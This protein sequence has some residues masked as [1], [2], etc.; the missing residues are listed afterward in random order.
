MN[1]AE[2]LNKN[3]FSRES[4]SAPAVSTHYST[5]SSLIAT[6]MCT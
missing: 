4:G 2:I 6:C 5:F 1:L 3:N